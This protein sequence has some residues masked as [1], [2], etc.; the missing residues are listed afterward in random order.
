MHN[1]PNRTLATVSPLK[2]RKEGVSVLKWGY[3]S[4]IVVS[5]YL[6]LGTEPLMEGC[7]RLFNKHNGQYTYVTSHS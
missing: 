5:P 4:D 1:I 7:D 3:F 2:D 6:V